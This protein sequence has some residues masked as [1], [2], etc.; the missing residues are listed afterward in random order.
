M[1]D[2]FVNS[3]IEM[4]HYS[5]MVYR[6]C[7]VKI[8]HFAVCL[9]VE[10]LGMP[11]FAQEFNYSDAY[12]RVS[13]TPQAA[14]QT[15]LVWMKVAYLMVRL[16]FQGAPNPAGFCGFSEVLTDLANK[17]SCIAI[18]PDK[19]LVPTVESG[20]LVPEEYPVLLAPFH[21]CILPAVNVPG[22]LA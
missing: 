7:L 10:H 22:G 18:V 15:I 19:F 12:R 5:E 11:I 14:A 13:H 2:A 9:R 3:R 1:E 6:W 4:S 8:L 16:A 17:I 21:Q 20:H